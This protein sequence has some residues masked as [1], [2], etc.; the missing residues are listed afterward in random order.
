[1]AIE[2]FLNTIKTYKLIQKGEGVVIGVS[3]GPDSICLLHLLWR[4][5]DEYSLKLYGVHLNHQFRGEEARKDALYVKDFCKELNIESFIF[6]ENIDFYAKNK[7]ITFEEAG[8]EWRYKLFDEIA[9]RTGSS[10]IA[11]A[12]NLNDQ[13]ETVLMR[14]MRGSGIEGLSAI[15]YMR[16]DKIIRPILN[17]SREEIEKYCEENGLNPR[18]DKTNFES[19]YTRNK[20]R[21]ELIPYMQEN[22]NP[23]IIETL[24]RNSDIFREDSDYL[25]KKAYEIFVN[26]S[27]IKENVVS[28]DINKFK[29]NHIAIK[30]RII[31][32]AIKK[33]KGDLKNIALTNIDDIIDLANNSNVGAKLNIS[34]DI[35]IK[36]GYNNIDIKNKILEHNKIIGD[37]I[38]HIELDRKIYLKEIDSTLEVS[39]ISRKD[40]DYNNK[41][42][43][44]IYVDA[45]KVKGKLYIRNRRRGDR[46]SPLGMKGSKKV[47]DYFINLKVPKELRSAVPILCDDSNIIWLIGYRMS[48]LYKIDGNTSRTY[49]IT[50]YNGCIEK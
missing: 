27:K 16:D 30:R 10:K 18:I 33:I 39:I 35:I 15:D 20:I 7:G 22:F 47:K 1:M 38:Y 29:E 41:D 9:E 8:R 4:I 24:A 49:K 36:L 28:I 6:S 23:N 31:R 50:Y 14:L 2:K 19:I 25:N 17:I 44:T 42:K 46:F 34:G 21:L 43:N 5:R 3:G 48:E 26:I 37:Y 40:I 45:H 13:A 12:Q 32:G 11:V